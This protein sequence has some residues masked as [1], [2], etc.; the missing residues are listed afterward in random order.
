M[1]E[2]ER[3]NRIWVLRRD[4]GLKGNGMIK[5]KTHKVLEMAI[6]NGIK[7]GY[8]R[9]YKHDDDPSEEAIKQAIMEAIKTE[10]YEWFVE[11]TGL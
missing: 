5:A 4:I 8:R 9:A 1:N 3:V 11:D 7:Y 10:I 2:V 6:E